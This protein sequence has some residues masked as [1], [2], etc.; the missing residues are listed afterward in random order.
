MSIKFQQLAIRK[1]LSVTVSIDAMIDQL[2]E[3]T[4]DLVITIPHIKNG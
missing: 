4:C 3:L 2:L 1:K